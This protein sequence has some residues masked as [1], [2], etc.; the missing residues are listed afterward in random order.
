MFC[1]NYIDQSPAFSYPTQK[2]VAGLNS[3]SR[4]CPALNSS[5]PGRNE[6]APLLLPGSGR[7]SSLTMSPLALF[8]LAL[9]TPSS[10]TRRPLARTVLSTLLGPHRPHSHEATCFTLHTTQDHEA[11]LVAAC[12]LRSQL[13]AAWPR[14]RQRPQLAVQPHHVPYLPQTPGQLGRF[15]RCCASPGIAYRAYGALRA[16]SHATRTLLCGRRAAARIR[17]D[18]RCPPLASLL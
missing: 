15:S 1:L 12:A 2:S 13:L 16:A 4:R 3:F 8:R 18:H 9:H 14:S 6:V 10:R 17:R 5:I 11:S 7:S